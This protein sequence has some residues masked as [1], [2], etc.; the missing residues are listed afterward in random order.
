MYSKA[1]RTRYQ[2]WRQASLAFVL[3]AASACTFDREGTLVPDASS[4][5]TDS[6]VQSDATIDS[7]ESD[8]ACFPPE[9]LCDG[10]CVDNDNP[11]YGCV[12]G[13][14]D[15]C[16]PR[17]HGVMGCATNECVIAKCEGSYWNCNG[18]PFDGCEV[19]LW[20]V[21]NCGTCGKP[22]IVANNAPSCNEGSCEIGT[23]LEPWGDCDGD[24]SNGCETKLRTVDNCGACGSVCALAGGSSTCVT[25]KCLIDVCEP[26][27]ADCNADPSDGCETD[28]ST[29]DNCGACDCPCDPPNAVG[30]C[31]EG[32]CVIE[33]CLPEYGDCNDDPLDGCEINIHQ[34]VDH[35]G[36]CEEPC[37]NAHVS[38]RACS[39]GLCKPTCDSG[40]RDCNGPEP[41]SQDDGC[42]RDVFTV[43][44]CGDCDTPCSLM[45]AV[46]ACPLG[47]CTMVSCESGWD[48]CDYVPF[49]GCER[50]VANDAHNCGQC[51]QVCLPHP[52]S[53]TSCSEGACVVSCSLGWGDCNGQILDGCEV[54]TMTSSWHCGA[55]GNA[56]PSRPHASNSCDLGQC[57]LSCDLGWGDCN[58]VNEDGCE[59]DLSLPAHCGSC[60]NECP[61]RPHATTTCD[62]GVC[63]FTCD[64]GWADC[65]T[66]AYDGCESDLGSVATCGACT[67]QCP[68]PANATAVCGTA[69]CSF[70][71]TTGFDDCNGQATDGCEVDLSQ[72]SDCGACG[73]TCATGPNGTPTC[74]NGSCGVSCDVG[75]A[76]CNLVLADGCEADLSSP[77]TCGSC[78]NECPTRPHATSTCSAGVCGYTC[79]SGWTDCDGVASN[80]CE[81]DLQTDASHC[82]GCGNACTAP[83]N[84]VPT[85]DAGSCSFECEPGWED[86]D[87]DASNGCEAS[88]ASPATCGSCSNECIAPAHATATCESASICGFACSSDWDDCDGGSANGCETD[89]LNDPDHCGDCSIVCPSGASGTDRDCNDGQCTLTCLPAMEDCNNDISDGCECPTG[90]C[91]AGG[92]CSC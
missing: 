26:G 89:L 78:S 62:Q 83:D 42:E 8:V 75:F 50:D 66:H 14:C 3:I 54:N 16:E 92:G 63:G 68:Q 10:L 47:V 32:E 29:L 38:S 61:T 19:D 48:D 81:A 37:E 34:N 55:C 18:D 28:L 24:V 65:N 1:S 85:C 51:N 40:W 44:D 88:L 64:G 41:G 72:I 22:C 56:C 5:T 49:N 53:T 30:A 33:T 25:G 80:G 31:E 46:S 7:V 59:A 9:K 69:G 4:P 82:G 60:S 43:T 2:W 70:V 27:R 74:Q 6:G 58:D 36:G 86:C 13:K 91:A 39:D 71:C 20:S 90:C 67:V 84:A 77:E 11:D 17:E 23:C 79:V 87:G 15:P 21:E 73:N 12:P 45:H 76:N 35:C 52:H 57:T